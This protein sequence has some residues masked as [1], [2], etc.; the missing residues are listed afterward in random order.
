MKKIQEIDNFVH[1]ISLDHLRKKNEYAFDLNCS[2]NGL[3]E[4]SEK[5]NLVEAKKASFSGVLTLKTKTQILL[6]GVVR[7]KLIQSCSLTLD[8][9]ITIISKK[10]S[11]TFSVGVTDYTHTKKSVFELTKK[12]FENDFILD[13]INLGEVFIETISLETP[14]YPKKSG[15]SLNLSPIEDSNLDNPFS[16]LSRLKK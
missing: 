1:N 13:Q 8:P 15:A 16:I 2:R 14:D 6:S 9:V 4:L 5:L 11:R 3:I 12:C 7:A 10:I